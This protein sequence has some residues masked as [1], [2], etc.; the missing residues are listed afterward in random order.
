MR[1]P[2]FMPIWPEKRP[3]GAGGSRRAFLKRRSDKPERHWPMHFL[4][5]I[6]KVLG[7]LLTLNFAVLWAAPV[8]IQGQSFRRGLG[9]VLRPVYQLVDGL[10]ALRSFAARFVYRRPVHVDYFAAAVL[11][12]GSTLVL[13][14]VLFATQIAFGSLPWWL[15]AV[16]YFL[17]VGPGGRSLATAWTL[18][19]R[20]G[21]LAGGRM[22]RPWLGDRIGNFFENWLGVFYGTVPYSFS[23]AHIVT[24]HR[25]DGGKGDPIYL[26]DIDRT[27]LGDLMLYQWR[28][29]RHM[30]G[31]A[32]LVELRR[33]QGVHPAVDRGRKS[34]RR[35]MAIYWIW[36]P[37]GIF[38]LL[39][40]TGSSVPAAL[41]FL[42][43][44]YLQPLFAM[45]TFL[46]II[47]IGQHGF[48]EFDEAGRHV[49]H[50]TST[51]VLDGADDSFGEDYHV[52]HHHFPGVDH[53]KLP[54]H[55]ARERSQWA[56][57]N[58][59][60]FEKT[61]FFEVAIA[62]CLGRCDRLIR[63]HYVDCGG[64][65]TVEE[66]ATLFEQRARR[67]EMTYEDYEFSYLPGLRDRVR[68]LVDQGICKDENRAYIYQSHN[69]I[70]WRENGR[71]VR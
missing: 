34:L 15:V 3:A 26:W 50:V 53:D 19:H 49:K 24:H 51:T 35:G 52:A 28:F 62:M 36:V 69:N 38:A 42:F 1:L 10:P 29:F 47:N 48:L 13:L 21:H 67:K 60:V 12:A 57:C 30:S 55:V 9:R 68:E 44:V 46:T 66:L 25:F 64:N 32:S 22:Y 17:W 20:E 8:I 58:G 37:S 63:D 43:F 54:E 56:R 27:R 6:R 59:A 14:S 7:T 33:E 41:L 31:I 70:E 40:G 23:A 71:A 5:G 65:L 4:V 18:A 39:I 2:N 16:Y 11:L 45:S 61:T